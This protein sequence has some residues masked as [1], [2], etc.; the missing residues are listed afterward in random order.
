MSASFLSCCPVVSLSLSLVIVGRSSFLGC[1]SLRVSR[2]D[3][4]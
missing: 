1:L 3:D 2:R 4:R